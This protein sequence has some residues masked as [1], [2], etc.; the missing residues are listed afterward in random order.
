MKLKFASLFFTMFSMVNIVYANMENDI[1]P[2]SK[3]FLNERKREL[4]KQKEYAQSCCPTLP[5]PIKD[6]RYLFLDGEYL[7]WKTYTIIPYAIAKFA[8]PPYVIEGNDTVPSYTK[9]YIPFDQ[10]VKTVELHAHTGYR[11][12]LGF[13]FSDCWLLLGTYRQFQSRGTDGISVGGAVSGEPRPGYSWIDMVWMDNYPADLSTPGAPPGTGFEGHPISANA[14]QRY[15]EK[16]LD[17]DFM[18]SFTYHRFTFNP[19]LGTRFAWLKTD[20]RVDYLINHS[21]TNTYSGLPFTN[22]VDVAN[23][24]NLGVGAHAGLTSNIDLGWGFGFGGKFAFSALVGQFQYAHREDIFDI[25]QTPFTITTPTLERSFKA[26]N[27]QTN[28][29]LG[30]NLNWGYH[31]NDCKYFLGLKAGYDVNIWPDFFNAIRQATFY[32]EPLIPINYNDIMSTWTESLLTH[33]LSL[34]ARFDF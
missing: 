2:Q 1:T 31:F 26:T 22:H 15:R 27:F 18:R 25:E 16:V 8:V 4:D 20:L 28:W 32:T 14:T 33:G 6:N 30:I 13:Y 29:E 11:L 19:F 17:I 7:Y 12:N 3:S 34:G 5:L 9:G 24:M 21:N 23:H 10:E